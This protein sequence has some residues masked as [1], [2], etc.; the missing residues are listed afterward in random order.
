[1]L[2]IFK[3]T[4]YEVFLN[5]L[6]AAGFPASRTISLVMVK[7]HIILKLKFAITLSKL[8]SIQRSYPV[9]NFLS[10][11]HSHIQFQSGQ[12]VV[13]QFLFHAAYMV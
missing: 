6:I 3:I 13:K 10:R 9:D 11:L 12:P 1:M 2:A 7:I 8:N 5:L 4:N